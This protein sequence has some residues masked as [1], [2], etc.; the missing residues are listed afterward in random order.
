MRLF[1]EWRARKGG[2]A[3]HNLLAG[4][5][6]RALAVALCG[7]AGAGDAAVARTG[8]QALR[9]L[10]EACSDLRLHITGTEGWSRAMVTRGGVALKEL[11]PSTLACRKVVNLFCVG[12]VV[13]LDGWC[14]GYNLTW[15]FASGRLAGCAGARQLS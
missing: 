2:R 14:G 10:A 6:P 1:G 11:E 13:D 15:A 4:E 3:L 8:K 7:L 9:A 5:M 12:E